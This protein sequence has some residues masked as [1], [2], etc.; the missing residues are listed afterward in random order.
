MIKHWQH[1]EV[2]S[3]LDYQAYAEHGSVLEPSTPIPDNTAVLICSSEGSKVLE[4][5]YDPELKA[6][7]PLKNKTA[8]NRDLRLYLDAIQTER[9]TMIAVDGLMGTGKTSTCVEEVINLYLSDVVLPDAHQVADWKPP[10]G[11]HTVMI[12]KPYVNS[13][14]ASERYGF[15]PGSVD[16]KI[17]PTLTNFI[18][19]FDRCHPFGFD[20]LH[21][22][23]YIKILPLGFIRG[24]DAKNMI[25]IADETQN[26][27][28]LISVAT[29]KA[30]SCRV[31]F[32][33]DTSPFQIDL[34]GNTPEKNGLS[35]LIDL[36]QGAPYFQYIEMKSLKHIVR[37]AEVRDI[38][39]RLFAKYGDNPKEWRT[40]GK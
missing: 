28:E 32:L 30:E 33:G 38:V 29:R 13:G 15:L 20:A 40:C 9:I 17:G 27:S 31:F 2:V 35:D 16:E 12:C 6:I 10:E 36:L 18:Q 14:G 3:P 26:T 4:G 34:P 25:I 1:T 24:L 22:A 21:K 23:E 19:Y 8:P 37:S 39:R 5:I 11:A 7:R